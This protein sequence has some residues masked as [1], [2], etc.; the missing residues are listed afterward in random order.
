MTYDILVVSYNT[1]DDTVA[2]LRSLLKTGARPDAIH[3]ADNGSQDGT[4][5][6]IRSEFPGVQLHVF[7]SNLYYARAMNHLIGCS[8]APYILVLNPDVVC[9]M[10]RLA[11]LSDHFASD[12]D[13]VALAPQLRFPDGRVQASCRRLPNAAT[14]WQEIASL[15]FHKPSRWKMGD[16]DH[17]S[18]ADV[19]QPMFSCLWIRRSAFSTFGT[20]DESYPLFFNDVEWCRRVRAAG[21]RIRFDPAVAVSHL[22]GGTTRRYPLRKLWHAHR[23]F[24]T[25]IARHSSVPGAIVGNLGVWLTFLAR[26]PFYG[27]SRRP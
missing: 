18:Q 12:P 15:L 1:R 17:R 4:A 20:L 3:V 11:A 16:F 7:D 10:S 22:Q 23:S 8:T 13:L 19:E 24:A 9:D 2:C 6:R 25:Y 27:L 14:P 21:K 5:E 26:L